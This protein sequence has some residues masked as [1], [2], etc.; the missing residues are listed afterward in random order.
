LSTT[1]IR[2]IFS[3]AMVPGAIR[4]GVAVA[5]IAVLLATLGNGCQYLGMVRARRAARAAFAR[6]P[7]LGLLRTLTPEESLRLTGRVEGAEGRDEPL[8]VVAVGHRFATDE[9]VAWR[10]VARDVEL[11]VLLLP[12]GDYDLLAFADL[13]RDGVFESTEMVG[14]TDPSA[15]VHVSGVAARDGFLV[16]GPALRVDLARP[17]TADVPIRIEV[18]R[19]R[20]ILPSL[21]DDFFAQRWGQLG[22]FHP[23]QLLVHTQGYLF[24][25]ED[26][27]PRK[28]QVVFVHGAGGSPAEFASLVDGLDR[29]R[30]QPWFFFYPSGLPLDQLAALLSELL[31]V[32]VRDLDL[33][34]VAV[35]A[36][37]MGG[38]VAHAALARLTRNDHVPDW[39]TLFVSIAT[40]Y[41]G[42]DA[43]RLGVER[44]P[45]VVPSWRDVAPDSRFL[46]AL[47]ATPLPEQLP[48]FLIFA[49]DNRSRVRSLPSGDGTVTLRSQLALP[50]HLRARR[51]YGIDANH[52]SVLTDPETR[53][54]LVTLLDEYA[55][56]R[57]TPAWLGLVPRSSPR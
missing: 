2:R 39:L 32:S 20:N 41:A 22:I 13:D 10:L 19:S 5:L 47:Y 57:G 15:R 8:L 40:P 24:G 9:V 25:L 46:R 3:G 43:A 55:A 35:V 49:Y 6:E 45:E 18:A 21:S 26:P 14:R 16:D 52:T 11:Y 4:R 17:A 44:A 27:D 23:E 56:P 33:R 51:S 29:S 42:H 28:T 1:P 34:R 37:S 31:E 36:H 7:R 38:L 53:A 54:I 12:E 50:V 48:F 30:F